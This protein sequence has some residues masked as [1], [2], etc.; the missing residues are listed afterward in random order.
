MSAHT[1]HTDRGHDGRRPLTVRVVRVTGPD[2]G[3]V[4]LGGTLVEVVTRRGGPLSVGDRVVVGGQGVCD[5]APGSPTPYRTPIPWVDPPT[6]SIA[7][8]AMG[9]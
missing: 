1:N 6:A 5:H 4:R 7:A 3:L 8:A 2:S 9:R